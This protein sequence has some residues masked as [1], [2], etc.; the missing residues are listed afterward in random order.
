MTFDSN[1]ET[2]EL[3]G[4]ELLQHGL[5]LRLESPLSSELLLFEEIA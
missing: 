4:L 1:G 2:C 5:S 3:T